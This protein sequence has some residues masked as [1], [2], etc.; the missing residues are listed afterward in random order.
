MRPNAILAA[1]AIAVAILAALV[2]AVAAEQ[3]EIPGGDTMLRGVL[4]RP[5]GAGPFPGVVALH[6][7]GGLV[8]RSGAVFRRYADWGSRLA[9]AGLAV[10][11]PDSFS[12]RGLNN[13]CRVRARKVRSSRER[14]VDA[15]TARRWLQAQPWAVKERVSVVGWADGG[16][17]S[18]WAVRAR[19]GARDGLPDFRSAVALYPGCRRLG[20]AAWAARI[21]T[22][23]LIGRDDDWTPAAS[24]EQMVAGA[25][26]R[27]ARTSIVVY[28]GAHHEF[29]RVDSPVRALSGLAFSADGSGQAH[30]GTDKAARTDAFKRVQ[31]WLMR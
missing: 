14:V 24:C 6:G 29:D 13:Q 26:G 7:C 21:P 18:L 28:P 10:L 19:T 25:R 27:T 5:D 3:V 16:I 9:A 17:A 22:L 8:N 2:P 11:F 30:V 20:E 23:I 15:L 12:S 31:E 1:A 4:Y